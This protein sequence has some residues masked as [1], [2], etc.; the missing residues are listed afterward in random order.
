MS[1]QGDYREA[2]NRIRI[3]KA[4]KSSELSLSE[5]DIGVL[6][7]ELFECTHLTSLVAWECGLIS[8]SP[9][10]SALAN[11]EYLDISNNQLT[12]VPSEI[13]A[14]SNLQSL[15]VSD[16]ELTQIPSEIFALFNLQS[17][18]VSFNQLTQLPSEI[19]NLSNLQSL[20]VSFNQLTQLPSEIGTLT[21][22]QTLDVTGNQ[23]IQLPSEIGALENLQSL[24]VPSNQLTQLPSEIGALENL[25]SLYVSG[26]QLEQIPS[27]IGTLT[28]LVTLD[29]SNNRLS[30]IHESLNELKNLKTFFL[31]NNPLLKLPPDILGPTFVDVSRKNLIPTNP[32]DILEYYFRT[33][34]G[35][36][37]LNEA[38]LILVGRG[39]VGKTSLVNRLVHKEFNKRQR[40]TDGIKITEWDLEL[41]KKDK[42]RLNVWDFGGQDIMHG[43]HQFFLTE[44]SLYLL[45]LDGRGGLEDNDAEYWLKL[46]SSFGGNSPVVVVL[47]K[48]NAH[49]FDLNRNAL[50]EKYPF[51]K[52]FVKTDCEDKTGIAQLLKTI[53]RETNSLENLR[54]PFPA[55]WFKIKEE[56]SKIDENY[57]SFDQF[58]E[59]CKKHGEKED[60][61]HELLAGYLHQ[62]GIALNYKDDPRLS[63]KHVLNPHWLT[64]GIYKILNSKLLE[65]KKGEI[66]ADDLPK[67]L[68]KKNYPA[69]M[70]CFL[71]DLLKRFELCFNF[72][73]GQ[74]HFLIPELLD[75]QEPKEAKNFIAE[76]CL[77][78]QYHYT[79]LPSGLL[80]RFIVRTYTLSHDLKRWRSGVILQLD[81][82]KALVKADVAEKK[83]F[84]SIQGPVEKRRKLLTLI[85]SDFERI[86]ADIKNL[87]PNEMVPIPG[88]PKTTILYKKLLELE[89][90]NISTSQEYV[91]G[92]IVTV[93]VRELLNGV[94]IE[95]QNTEGLKVFISYSHKDEFYKNQLETHL[96]ILK[97]QNLVNTW[98]DR[99]IYPGE[100]WDKKIK[101]NLESADIICL[102]ISVDFLASDYCYD[103]EMKRAIERHERN[104]AIVIPIFVRKCNWSKAPFGNIQGLPKYA[105]HVKSFK[106]KDEAW[107][108]ISKAIE[109]IALNKVLKKKS[110]PSI[111]I[112]KKLVKILPNDE[113]ITVELEFDTMLLCTYKIQLREKN[114]N[115]VVLSTSGDNSNSE[116]DKFVIGLANESDSRTVWIFFTVMDQTGEGGKY[117]IRALFKQNGKLI[118]EGILS[119][120]I[121]TISP[122]EN[123][124][125]V[126]LFALLQTI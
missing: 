87:L 63:D 110:T 49:P 1:R 45:V 85:R 28:N 71:L 74:N 38:K 60:N 47:N 68:D 30:Q 7:D 23:L 126:S 122:G 41:K 111:V 2:L 26:N 102:L 105:K 8:L 96:K 44:R 109:N 119:S 84:I 101:D 112:A 124:Q 33:R 58:K 27:E 86:H 55:V 6:P 123:L 99:K 5:L 65:E 53:K 25:Q 115:K 113:V 89:K 34:E 70:H 29:V 79:I 39:E 95:K 90:K 46:I 56:I 32:K 72:P 82:C 42:V 18:D 120:G 91:D 13:C 51:I 80:S 52:E 22:L 117:E 62:L 116:E 48:I 40:K 54:T 21:I 15:E 73:D 83:A 93:N 43:T 17:L 75:K 20:D 104:E 64:N 98:D 69:N 57:L 76:E 11:L 100:E 67:I 31:H 125:S 10:I 107:T 108:E 35:K 106:D 97:R 92:N 16:N 118:D 12:Q 94:D 36:R 114:S 61:A 24:F 81:G 103:I 66:S 4:G 9:E 121:R 88:A 59:F 19:G 3:A 14:L 37:P 78:F 50:K 77:N